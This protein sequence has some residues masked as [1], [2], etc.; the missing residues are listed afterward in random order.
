VHNLE[1]LI[2]FLLLMDIVTGNS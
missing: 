1:N 2:K